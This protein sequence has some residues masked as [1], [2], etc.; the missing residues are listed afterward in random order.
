MRLDENFFGTELLMTTKRYNNNFTCNILDK[1]GIICSAC[2][3]CISA[4]GS[5]RNAS[6]EQ[7]DS[8]GWP[9]IPALLTRRLS[10]VSCILTIHGTSRIRV[11]T[12]VQVSAHLCVPFVCT[13]STFLLLCPF[14]P[15]Q[16]NHPQLTLAASAARLDT[17]II[18]LLTLNRRC[19]A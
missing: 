18:Q 6:A 7:E 3:L 17:Q 10:A 12:Y 16:S 9:R 2:L 4:V 14:T 8:L 15:L 1:L 13:P 11:C 5:S 19:A